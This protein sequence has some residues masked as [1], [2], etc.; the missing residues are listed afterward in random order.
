MKPVNGKQ[1][2]QQYV[3][4]DSPQS[5]SWSTGIFSMA[6]LVLL[7]Q[8]QTL[9]SPQS[10]LYFCASQFYSLFMQIFA[11]CTHFYWKGEKNSHQ[12]R[13]FSML[14][15]QVCGFQT[16]HWFKLGKKATQ[17]IFCPQMKKESNFKSVPDVC[18]L[19]EP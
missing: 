5:C 6:F 8:S 18:V 7:S 15:G 14:N 11:L 1:L 9:L 10:V 12:E 16:E 3:E 4:L 17:V 13:G 19:N 2:Q